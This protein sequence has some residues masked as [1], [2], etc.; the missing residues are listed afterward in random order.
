MKGKYLFYLFLALFFGFITAN[1]FYKAYQ[2]NINDNKY[3]AYLIQIGSYKE[4]DLEVN[5]DKYLVIE[6]NGIYNVYAG[7]TTSLVNASKIK[8]IY[9]E[10]QIQSFIK[11][12]VIDNV[13]FISNLEQYD[14]LLSEVEDEDNLISINDVIISSYEEMVLEK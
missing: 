8:K 13:E 5:A 9:E 4:N 3:N 7:I 12:T 11:P 14:I 2:K 6:E 1:S 10:Q